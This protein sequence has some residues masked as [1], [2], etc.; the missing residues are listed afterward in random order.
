MNIEH[1]R[2]SLRQDYHQG[3]FQGL[4]NLATSQKCVLQHLQVL[5][6]SAGAHPDLTAHVSLSGM[7]DENIYL[8]TGGLCM[9]PSVRKLGNC[10][11]SCVYLVSKQRRGDARITCSLWH[12]VCSLGEYIMLLLGR[13]GRS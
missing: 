11:E 5:C 13:G 1:V 4:P 3:T 7:E 8:Q 12:L 2:L 9:R 10:L 6:I